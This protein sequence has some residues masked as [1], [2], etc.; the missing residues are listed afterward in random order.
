MSG[1]SFLVGGGSAWTLGTEVQG[2]RMGRD[3]EE[4]RSGWLTQASPC[5]QRRFGNRPSLPDSEPSGAD[6]SHSKPQVAD[7]QRR[8][9][10]LQ[11]APH[12]CPRPLGVFIYSASQGSSP[13]SRIR[14]P[15][16][17]KYSVTHLAAK[18][19]PMTSREATRACLCLLVN[20]DASLRLPLGCS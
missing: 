11:G 7:F 13:W 15:R 16:E 12:L 5:F 8:I 20:T 3:G 1:G 17:W 9:N 4:S 18:P 14:K 6:R 19:D 2:A 10:S